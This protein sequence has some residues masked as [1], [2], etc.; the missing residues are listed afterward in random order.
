MSIRYKAFLGIIVIFGVGLRLWNAYDDPTL[1]LDEVFSAKMAEMPVKDLLL[2]VPR[3]DTH[4]PLYYLQL[5][6]WALIGHT[7][8][9]LILNSV[10]LDILAMLSLCYATIRV[11]N[12]DTGFWAAAVYAV[13]PLNIF[14]A[15]NVR[16][17]AMFFLLI[18]WLWYFL[19][20]R[21][22]SGHANLGR[23]LG[24]MLLG[25]AATLT[26]GLGFFVVFFIYLQSI[27]RTNALY[28]DAQGRR[29]A[30]LIGLD[31]IPVALA[32]GYSL[33]IGVF[34]QTEG[35]TTLD[36]NEL[37]IHLTIALLGMEFPASVYAGYIAFVLILLPP[38]FYRQTRA[39]LMWLVL[40]PLSILLLISLMQKSI[41]MYRTVG[42]FWPF[43][44]LSLGVLYQ[45][46]WHDKV[47]R[48][49][50]FPLFVLTLF[51]LASLNTSVAFRKAGFE[52]IAAT[53]DA[54]AGSE[55]ILFVPGNTQLWGTARYLDESP[56][57]SALEIQPPVRDGLLRLKKKLNGSYFDRAGFFGKEDHLV[58]GKREIWP[59]PNP[60][61]LQM[62]TSYWTLNPQDGK[63]LREGDHVVGA[64]ATIG[65]VLIE[66]QSPQGS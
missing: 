40:L 33:A 1:W 11:Y 10:F 50:V 15:S 3:F 57:F 25:L 59:Y 66:C 46:L 56:A 5:H 37:G 43:L 12:R 53:W 60:E 49:S 62:L 32:A 52:G 21:V 65:H 29:A 16:M 28:R 47:R 13:L 39:S 4:P 17:Y 48:A 8:S 61:R 30:R 7:D 63:C 27:V 22:R 42:L 34:R 18:I 55:A 64:Y 24:A 35:V 2:A 51:S 19:E 41:F 54:Q 58:V 26:H 36:F 9:W 6:F 44:A 20:L 38:M 31:Y 14:F 23:R 45:S